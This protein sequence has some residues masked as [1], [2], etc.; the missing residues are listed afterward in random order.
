[1]IYTVTGADARVILATSRPAVA[2][3]RFMQQLLTD[4]L[5]VEGT[6]RIDCKWTADG[7]WGA[8]GARLT[9]LVVAADATGV[10][11]LDGDGV[12]STLAAGDDM[13]VVWCVEG[14]RALE[15]AA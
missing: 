5:P 2:K 9:R 12:P 10:W 13:A 1:M 6:L 14:L 15:A 4:G 8:K 7:R 11:D 3:R